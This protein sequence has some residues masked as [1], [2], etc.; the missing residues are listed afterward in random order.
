MSQKINALC[1]YVSLTE[2]WGT[3]MLRKENQETRLDHL[4]RVKRKE[5]KR[6][7]EELKACVR[8]FLLNFY[9]S[10]ND[11]PLKIM[12]NIFYFI[13]KAH[14]VLSSFFPCQPLLP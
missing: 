7:V 10:P 3:G 14:F 2:R 4:Y 6:A 11:S 9:F 5:Y 8:Y 1:K 12:K 13:K